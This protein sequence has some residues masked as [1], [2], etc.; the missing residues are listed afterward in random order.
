MAK[1]FGFDDPLGERI[2]NGG[3]TW[4]VVGVLEDFHFESMKEEIGPLCLVLGNSP[5]TI[6]V[7]VASTDM[8]GTIKA[9]AA[10]WDEFVPQQPVRYSFLD[11]SYA[12]MYDDVQRT[13]SVFTAFAIFAI[14]VACLG[15]FGLSAFVVE[16]R[17]KEISIRKVLGASLGNIF[18]LVTVDFVKLVLIALVIAVPVSWYLMDRWLADYSYRIEI[19]WDVFAIAGLTSVLI[20][21]LTISS[22]SL[23]AALLNP[24]NKLRSE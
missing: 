23:K 21:L 24:V 3:G 8:A 11:E 10:L 19:T 7:K 9:V 12:R 2:T 14:L 15:L 6:A 18:T 22:E 1:Q 4:N 13:G 5:E 16:Q 17:G 20:A